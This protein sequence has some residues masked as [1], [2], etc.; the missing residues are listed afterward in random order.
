MTSPTLFEEAHAELHTLLEACD[1]DR[2]SR[3]PGPFAASGGAAPVHTVVG[4][5]HLFRRGTAARLGALA[6]AA[7]DTHAPDAFTFAEALGLA[8]TDAWPSD[9]A[10]RAAWTTRFSEDPR[11]LAAESRA[12]WLALSVH[13]R[14]RAKL[15]FEPVEDYRI[16]FED[17]FGIRSDAEERDAAESAAVEVVGGQRDGT[18]P[19]GLGIRVK[20]LCPESV[21]RSVATLETFV[22]TLVRLGGRVPEGF[23]VTLPKV[24]L[25]EQPRTLA[26][27][28]ARLEHRHGLDAGALGLELMIELTRAVIAADGTAALPRLLAA[29]GGRCRAVH[30]GTYDYT[31]A[32]EVTAAHQT[33][34]HPLARFAL[35]VTQNV[36]A[37]THVRLSDGATNLM[38]V[39]P[40]AQV[41]AA[42]ST[43]YRHVRGSL[44]EGIHQGWDLHPAQLPVRFAAHH[45]LCLEGLDASTARLRHFLER[46]AQASLL[47]D[48]FDDAATGQGLLNHF[49]RGRSCGA[50]SEAELADAGLTEAELR[51]RS[52]AAILASRRAAAGRDAGKGPS[53][54]Q[55]R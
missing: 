47:G 22:D 4:G 16:D 34:A 10:V 20:A 28:L 45:A 7:L 8:G 21:A 39:G 43:M 19:R 30:F 23:V 32:C 52:F 33:M 24:E 2:A 12:A 3:G 27:L 15:A 42:W 25:P 18:L 51:T 13:A 41:H 48:V 50:L 38:P 26:R 9:P 49:L 6:L 37:G 35:H 46:A 11:G 17:G 29:S 1:A 14:V 31:A 36:V 54:R 44:S 5:A 40:T 55:T 53:S